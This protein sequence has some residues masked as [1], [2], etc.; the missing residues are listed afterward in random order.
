MSLYT[1]V[2]NLSQ[3]LS[4]DESDTAKAEIILASSLAICLPVPTE[5]NGANGRT[6]FNSNHLDYAKRV[7]NGV[8]EEFM[9]DVTKT[10]KLVT[11]IYTFRFN[12]VHEANSTLDAFKALVEHA[13]KEISPNETTFPDISSSELKSV[14][15]ALCGIDE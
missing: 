2:K 9:I 8:N 6:Y 1:V 13:Y 15:T 14:V 4:T 12:T 3:T 10:L 11:D 7:I 5:S